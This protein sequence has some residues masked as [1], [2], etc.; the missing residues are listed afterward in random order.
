M[1]NLIAL[2][3][4]A[5]NSSLAACSSCSQ[6]LGG[7]S[8]PS[9]SVVP[10]QIGRTVI[11]SHYGESG[12]SYLRRGQPAFPVL[13]AA[14]DSS[15]WIEDS[16]GSNGTETE[17]GNAAN[18]LVWEG[19]SEEQLEGLV[20]FGR[21]SFSTLSKDMAMGLVLQAATATG[22][23]TGSGLEGPA[24]PREENSEEEE[25]LKF[26]SLS[27][28]PR[29]KMRVAFTCNKCGE[30]TTRAINP[31]AYSDGTV[32]VQCKGCDVFHKLVDNLKLFHEMNG[33]LYRGYDIP[34]YANDQ[35]YDF[36]NGRY[37]IDDRFSS[38]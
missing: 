20:P 25:K 24:I 3:T 23:T 26:P 30:R 8:S 2:Q 33:K 32:F 14:R 12:L 9:S 34:W 35:P 29:R 1:A 17:D 38:F 7:V 31:H 5:I 10:P 21:T 11:Q 19:K 28:S 37:P 16:S 22:W 6:R 27:K 18:P 36:F 4:S 13:K 15:E